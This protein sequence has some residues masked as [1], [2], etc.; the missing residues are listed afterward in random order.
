MS[1]N[2]LRQDK[3]SPVEDRT[4]WGSLEDV[5]NAIHGIT[6]GHMGK[7]QLSA[8]DPIFWLREY[9]LLLLTTTDQAQI[10]RKLLND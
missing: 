2:L 7:T 10:M 3:D 4:N 9:S 1:N 6:G 8:F 5:H